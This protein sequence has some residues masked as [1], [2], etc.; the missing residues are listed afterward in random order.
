MGLKL[1]NLVEKLNPSSKKALEA[2]AALCVQ[3]TNYN[4]ELEHFLYKLLQ[5]PD[6][7]IELLLRHYEIDKESVQ[8]QLLNSID[9]FKQGCTISPTL[10]PNIIIL[11]EKAWMI[12]SIHLNQHQIRSAAILLALIDHDPLRGVILESCPLIL[13]IPRHIL[14][15]DLVELVRVS[16]E[17][18][19]V[20]S[21]TA[22]VLPTLVPA[23]SSSINAGEALQKYAL[24]LTEQAYQGKLDPVSGREAEVHQIID[25]LSRKKQNNPILVGDA[26]VGKTAIIEGLAQKIVAGNVPPS[27][28]NTQI[29]TLDLGLL[30][31]GAGV[32]GDFEERLK[33]ILE[34]VKQA[35]KPIIL[36]IDE[37]HTLIGAGGNL[38]T[39]DAANLLKPSLA[40]G[41]LRT[42]AATTWPEY[43]RYI[44]ND[45]A[46]NRR[47]ELIKIEEPTPENAMM[48]LR[49]F[50]PQLEKHHDVQVLNEAVQAAVTLSKRF[51]PHRRLPDKAI[52]LLDT[53]CARVSL[54][55]KATPPLIDELNNELQ[56]L[57]IE[58]SMLQR[59]TKKSGTHLQRLKEITGRIEVIK[60]KIKDSEAL[61]QQIRL[62]IDQIKALHK[63]LLLFDRTS[64]DD[65]LIEKLNH[66]EETTKTLSRE[67]NLSIVVDRDCI[68]QI[69]SSWTGIPATTMLSVQH[70]VDFESIFQNLRSKIIGQDQALKQLSQAVLTYRTGLADP[71]KP[72][73]VFLLVGPSGVGKTE[74]AQALATFLSG[75]RDALIRLNMSEFQEAHSLASLKGAPPGYVGYG[76][77]GLLTEAVRRNPY[78]VILLDEIEKAHRDVAN[79]F[80]QVFDKGIMEDGEGV[81]VDFRNTLIIMTSNLGA[82]LVQDLSVPSE[83]NIETGDILGQVLSTHFGPALLARMT[84]IPYHS[85]TL[86]HLTEIT[87]L[88]LNDIKERILQNYQANLKIK[89]AD[90]IA[91]L[92][93]VGNSSQGARAIDRILNTQFLPE[94]SNF[95]LK[96]KQTAEPLTE[97][98]LAEL[99]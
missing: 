21:V 89:E 3:K 80:Y 5:Q 25:V 70:G 29:Y 34:D 26:G 99:I 78:S 92:G 30:Q 22:P 31:S 50:V 82:E 24:N 79:L 47:F 11:L 14:R 76:K 13:R 15:G 59:E 38:G 54:A 2:A 17:N 28:Q 41:E 63:Q 87:H 83:G 49:R 69:L 32:R 20:E 56:L 93:R 95:I 40:R 68:A 75:S 33:G 85:L 64:T 96:N 27:L 73:G 36:F 62:L 12:T 7:D 55:H 67:L 6:S 1:K 18:R 97:I 66:L 46:L 37:A 57:Q 81:R 51:L 53:A 10:S 45:A 9:K 90:I 16:P 52:N 77:G 88:K 94:L 74:T 86:T 43:K 42:I 84:V 60:L 44:E 65:A 98:T 58:A 61:W 19:Y 71:G 91:I 35:K 4:V 23:A 39:N 8:R 48:M 72:M